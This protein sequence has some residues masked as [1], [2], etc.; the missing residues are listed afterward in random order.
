MNRKKLKIFK[1]IAGIMTV[2]VIVSTSMPVWEITGGAKCIFKEI[3]A[4]AEEVI[5][6]LTEET[7]E[8]SADPSAE[9][10]T[11][12]EP[13]T[14]KETES[15][16]VLE[17]TED[18]IRSEM[19]ETV[20]L[21]EGENDGYEIYEDKM[22]VNI[23][24]LIG[25]TNYSKIYESNQNTYCE[26]DIVLTFQGASTDED[27]AD[28]KS[29]GNEN[30]PFKGDIKLTDT[31]NN[32]IILSTPMFDYIS[33]SSRIITNGSEE[34][35]ELIIQK[36]GT[37]DSEPLFANHVVHDASPE[38]NKSEWIITVDTSSHDFAGIVSTIE[39]GAKVNL[40]IT[41]KANS[42][43]YN[44]NSSDGNSGLACGTMGEN[45][46]LAVS[47]SFGENPSLIGVKSTGGNA[48]GLVGEMKSGSK[49][50]L[51]SEMNFSEFT[52][53][54]TD[55][56][57]GCAGGLVGKATDAE[58]VFNENPEGG[59]YKV[60][61]KVN[62]TKATGGVF[63]CYVNSNTE[64]EFQ[65]YNTVCDVTGNNAGGVFGELQNKKTESAT[66][67]ITFDQ[68]NNVITKRTN[69][70]ADTAHYGG[71]IG[72]YTAD[73]SACALNIVGTD[74][75][76]LN[77]TISKTG[78][79]AN[80]GGIIGATGSVNDTPSNTYVYCSNVTVKASGCNNASTYFGG[81]IGKQ[82]K[83]TIT[84]GNTIS[85]LDSGFLDINNFTVEINN[86]GKGNRQ[87]RGGGVVGNMDAG[88]LQF[89]GYT[90]LDATECVVNNTSNDY[91]DR[92]GQIVGLRGYKANEDGQQSLIYAVKGWELIRSRTPVKADDI[93]TWGEVIR[94]SDKLNIDDVL[95]CN[96]TE[97]T[98]TV[99]EIGSYDST[100]KE[101]TISNPAEF[102]RL[103]INMKVHVST[104]NNDN[105]TIQFANPAVL[106]N[107]NT[108]KPDFK[109]LIKG[110]IDLT[111]TGIT[112]IFRD[113][114][115]NAAGTNSYYGFTKTIDGKKE[116]NSNSK[117]TLAIGEP[118]GYRMTD[119]VKTE[120]DGTKDGDG[121]IYR[122]RFVGLT[123]KTLDGAAYHNLNITGTVNVE[124]LGVQGY[125]EAF[126]GSFAA[127]NARGIMAFNNVKTDVEFN[128]TNCLASTVRCGGLIGQIY[129]GSTITIKDSVISPTITATGD[130]DICTGGAIGDIRPNTS[131]KITAEDI[132][133]GAKIKNSSKDDKKRVGGFIAAIYNADAES[134]SRTVSL[135]KVF[136]NGVT[137]ENNQ[138]GA[139][140]G[141][142]WYN[143]DVIFGEKDSNGNGTNG[144][145]INNCKITQTN[146]GGFAG[147]IT[148]GTGYWQVHHV[149]INNITVDGGKAE[150]FGMF[151]N[152]S[153]I[154]DSKF[155]K[156]SPYKNLYLEFTN[157]NAYKIKDDKPTLGSVKYFDEI[158]VFAHKDKAKD[159]GKAVNGNCSVVSIH[160][161]DNGN[162]TVIMGGANC[163]TYSNQT[164]FLKSEVNSSKR[165]NPYVRYYYNIDTIRA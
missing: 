86:D 27:T 9:E 138:G 65:Y 146:T 76:K 12:T 56:A 43:S 118:Y 119:N 116:D 40:S 132:T 96:T 105:N 33:D 121:K 35:K 85:Y 113:N 83:C 161:E 131:L 98:V 104:K 36:V 24:S 142:D 20:I 31:N 110:D 18:I 3:T 153:S 23:T 48:G 95:V 145:T 89:S 1:R 102:A 47:Y 15:V 90:N 77:V 134:S 38:F 37:A 101:L 80:Y 165:N 103:A 4:Y 62:G 57:N 41:N 44:Y 155:T 160:T 109:I 64:R 164:N 111:G 54:A 141:E 91:K 25:L 46:E 157:N 151:V 143:V 117:I 163:N 30:C 150:S 72:L 39:D 99:K 115:A 159:T 49:L 19:E 152:N 70:S 84:G 61:A 68:T 144:L 11:E 147:L 22:E 75:E 149:N 81:F 2:I 154:Y 88:V 69:S 92:C 74:A 79:A 13:V 97:H 5:E 126:I 139:L 129:E 162:P 6:Q 125:S 42:N 66:G 156:T 135:K 114:G 21:Q 87:F 16:S 14:E 10:T 78:K 53:S 7:T 8:P 45:S 108:N 127:Q 122:H 67:S 51:N 136:M 58:V 55:S 100:K 26:Y 128:I 63:G 148:N 107:D 120:V 130:K 71:L 158:L 59:Y 106:A 17:E 123:A 50:V 34:S 124:P 94:F 112:G 28:F 60:T 140:L 82:G 137:I 29:I 93:G 32:K 52:V 73:N 133:I